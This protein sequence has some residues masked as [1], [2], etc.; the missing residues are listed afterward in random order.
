MAQ[1]AHNPP[2]SD[3]GWSVSQITLDQALIV[4]PERPGPTLKCG[5]FDGD[6]RYCHQAVVWRR[7][8]PV[9]LRT[10][11]P[12]I[13][14]PLGGRWLWG[15]VLYNHFG[16]FQVEGLSRLWPLPG[17]NWDVDG[18]IFVARDP[19]DAAIRTYQAEYLRLLIGGV[20]VRVVTRPTRV[21]HLIVPGQGFG[22]GEIGAG[23]RI[24]RRFI[25]AH[26]A[27]DVAPAGP[28][29]L[30]VS[31]SLQGAGKGGISGEEIINDR[32]AREGYE[33]FHP[34]AH[35]ISEQIARYRAARQIVGFDGS[36]F[37]LIAMVARKDQEL[38]VLLRRKRGRSLSLQR[39]LTHFTKREPLIVNGF[40]QDHHAGRSNVADLD[41]SRMGTVL[42]RGGFIHA[43]WGPLSDEERDRV[44]PV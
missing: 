26:F 33:V 38:A 10:D 27:P 42:K 19:A 44:A 43:D 30:Y 36:A 22:L 29:R 8:K 11:I 32:M 4:P 6:G 23:T 40:T 20:P 41:L 34:E 21:S 2:R 18:V 12:G 15:G 7:Q 31:R 25:Q 24:F 35:S 13:S 17:L 1:D 5:V 14:E 39:H 28:G 16:H 3:G 37:H 9:T